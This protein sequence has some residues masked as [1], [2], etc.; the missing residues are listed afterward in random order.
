MANVG[1]WRNESEHG[2]WGS[3]D[4][5]EED[6]KKRWWLVSVIFDEVIEH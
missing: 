1:W 4:E 3:D 6:E 2:R 5:E